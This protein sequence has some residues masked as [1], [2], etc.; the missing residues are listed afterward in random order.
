MTKAVTRT[1][2]GGFPEPELISRSEPTF[3]IQSDDNRR[4]LAVLACLET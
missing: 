3:A 1:A 4:V 2:L